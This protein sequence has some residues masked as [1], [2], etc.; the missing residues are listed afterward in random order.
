MDAQTKRYLRTHDLADD[1]D[2]DLDPPLDTE[3]DAVFERLRRQNNPPAATD[4]R[5]QQKAW[6]R[7]IAKL[8]RSHPKNRS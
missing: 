8:W 2:D 3:S 5:Q 4:R 6:G 1:L 7:E